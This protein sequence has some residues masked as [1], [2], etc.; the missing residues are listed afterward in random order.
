MMLLFD[1][2]SIVIRNPNKKFSFISKVKSIIKSSFPHQKVRP[3]Q[4]EFQWLHQKSSGL[5]A[6]YFT[7]LCRRCFIIVLL[8]S[9]LF[10][11]TKKPEKYTNT[12]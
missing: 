2:S 12:R 10:F 8:S 7:I 1:L 5:F 3:Q 11:L 9:K 4:V 6:F